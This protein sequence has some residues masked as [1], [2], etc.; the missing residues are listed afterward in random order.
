[1]PKAVERMVRLL[2]TMYDPAFVCMQC[3]DKTKCSLCGF[4][5]VPDNAEKSALLAM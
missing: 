1:M 5:Q 2:P 3:Q 4:R